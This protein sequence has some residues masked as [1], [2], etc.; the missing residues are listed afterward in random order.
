ME[1]VMAR[2]SLD[3]E[4]SRIRYELRIKSRFLRRAVDLV[5]EADL[6]QKNIVDAWLEFTSM[7]SGVDHPKIPVNSLVALLNTLRLLATHAKLLEDLPKDAI[8][9]LL[10][11][12]LPQIQITIAHKKKASGH[13]PFFEYPWITGIARKLKKLLQSKN[14][15][16]D[17]LPESRKSTKS[18]TTAIMLIAGQPFERELD[19]SL[20]KEIG[21]FLSD[22]D[23]KKGIVMKQVY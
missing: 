19:E 8:V 7:R 1:D 4:N 20:L 16:P 13:W 18:R 15:T 11:A 2:E 23:K 21:S 22:A 17:N 12:D 5:F 3:K 14:Y 6:A 10:K 9:H